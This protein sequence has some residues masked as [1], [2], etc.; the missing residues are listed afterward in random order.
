MLFD[1]LCP[2]GTPTIFWLPALLKQQPEIQPVLYFRESTDHQVENGNLDRDMDFMLA[3]LHDLGVRWSAIY[4]GRETSY[5]ADYLDRPI[6]HRAAREAYRLNQPLVASSYSRLLRSDLRLR[7]NRWCVPTEREFQELHKLTRGVVLATWL[8][9]TV[10][11]KPNCQGHRLGS[12]DDFAFRQ[13]R[14][15]PVTQTFGR[16]CRVLKLDSN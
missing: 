13:W 12:R 1:G 7:G 10:T 9:P 5:S 4:D 16:R 3:S 15:F 2:V 8:R 11:R 6:L 14:T